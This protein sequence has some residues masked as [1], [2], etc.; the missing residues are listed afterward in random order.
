MYVDYIMSVCFAEDLEAD[1]VRAQE[2]CTSLQLG[3]R[4]VADDKTEP[5]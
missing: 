4:S 5:G 1:L 2:K 3:P